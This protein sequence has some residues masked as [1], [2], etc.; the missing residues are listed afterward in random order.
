MEF[1]VTQADAQDGEGGPVSVDGKSVKLEAIN[2]GDKLDL[3][4]I[5]SDGES[6]HVATHRFSWQVVEGD[7]GAWQI[8]GN[9]AAELGQDYIDSYDKKTIQLTAPDGTD[10]QIT[11]QVT[12]ICDEASGANNSTTLDIQI[13]SKRSL[14]E[15][16]RRI[17]SVREEINKNLDDKK[18]SISKAGDGKSLIYAEV[19]H[20]ATD[21]FLLEKE[22]NLF[23]ADAKLQYARVLKE[24][25]KK[26]NYLQDTTNIIHSAD[27]YSVCT[28]TLPKHYAYRDE[29]YAQ[30]EK[31]HKTLCDHGIKLK[32]S[33]NE[34]CI[35]EVADRGAGDRIVYSCNNDED[36]S[37]R[38]NFSNKAGDSRGQF[39]PYLK[40]HTLYVTYKLTEDETYILTGNA[41][42]L[43]G[44]LGYNSLA[45]VNC[46]PINGE[47]VCVKKIPQDQIAGLRLML[48]QLHEKQHPMYCGGKSKKD[49]ANQISSMT[50]TELG[51]RDR[52][53]NENTNNQQ[54]GNKKQKT[55]SDAENKIKVLQSLEDNI[56]PD[57]YCRRVSYFPDYANQYQYPYMRVHPKASERNFMREAK[58]QRKRVICFSVRISSSK[59][60]K[61]DIKFKKYDNTFFGTDCDAY[62]KTVPVKRINECKNVEPGDVVTFFLALPPPEIGG[63]PIFDFS[64]YYFG[65]KLISQHIETGNLGNVTEATIKNRSF[66]FQEATNLIFLDIETNDTINMNGMFKDAKNFNSPIN[67]WDVSKVEDMSEMFRGAESF[68]QPLDEWKLHKLLYTNHMFN[69]ARSFKKNIRAWI[70]TAIFHSEYKS[71]YANCPIREEEKFISLEMLLYKFD[72]KELEK[73]PWDY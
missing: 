70:Q 9:E 72:H 65:E 54:D 29:K 6:S 68:N 3:K 73:Y 48:S 20:N 67:E 71:M 23:D 45:K 22:T 27:G 15:I 37:S 58:N 43:P 66:M 21:D 39:V 8:N 64:S 52:P 7:I 33:M 11:L 44:L 56:N 19:I 46:D 18:R 36:D 38:Q 61:Y 42:D 24:T 30:Q 49:C 40:Q 59:Q 63:K 12:V 34:T 60:E 51:K 50:E 53:N 16:N 10:S 5:T 1:I 32:E 26:N 14:G 62:R 25:T 2:P 28:D 35:L 41:K 57:N 17:L 13:A 55:N 4:L 31:H 69:G 47:H